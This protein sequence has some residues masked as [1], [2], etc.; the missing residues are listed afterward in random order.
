MGFDAT[1]KL[2]EGEQ[3]RPWLSD[4]IRRRMIKKSQFE[5]AGV[6]VYEVA[7]GWLDIRIILK[8]Q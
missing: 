6:T 1:A 2:P 8:G 4:I 5:L 7:Y 3:P